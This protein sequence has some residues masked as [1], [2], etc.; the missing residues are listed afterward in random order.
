M[1]TKLLTR[2]KTRMPGLWG[3]LLVETITYCDITRIPMGVSKNKPLPMNPPKLLSFDAHG[4]PKVLAC[5]HYLCC[6]SRA[7]SQ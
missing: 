1:M 3:L 5:S 2:L 7:G 6:N 4:G